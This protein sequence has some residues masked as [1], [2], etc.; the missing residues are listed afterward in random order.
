MS[1]FASPD[2]VLSR[3]AAFEELRTSLAGGA[4]CLE[5]TGLWGS[6]RALVIAGL[7]H[8]AGRP[9]LLVTA[10]P[11]ERHRGA[12]DI[13]FFLS[14]LALGTAAREGAAGRRVLELPAPES[15]S[16]R[17]GRNREQ[18][19]ERA[20][21]CYA[22]IEGGGLVIVAT[23]SALSAALLTP[24][25]FVGRTGRL[26]VGQSISRDEL[27]FLL[28]RAGYERVE[29]VVEVGQWSLRGGIVD[30]FSPARERPVRAEFLGDEIESLRLFDPTT[31][32]SVDAVAEIE[33]LPLLTKDA[34]T[35]TVTAYLP[36]NTL[37][38]L[39]D[40]ALLEAP[41]DDAPAAVPLHRLLEGY[42]RL[43]MPLLSR[44]SGG[45]ARI[46]MG[47]RSVGA[48]RGQFKALAEEIKGWR[49]EGFAVRLAVDDDRQAERVR[50]TLVEHELEPWPGATLW[51]PEGLGVI[52]GECGSGFQL[53]ALGLVLLSER[54]VFG[55]QR[56]R[57]RRP[58]F[59]RGAAIAAFTDL[60]PNDLVVHEDH[61]IGRYHGLR[62]LRTDERDA[63]FLLLE[64]A[65]GGRLY[66]PVARLDLITKYMGAP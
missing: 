36:A 40:P 29:T 17:G 49:E 6:S 31:Q 59:Q 32:R 47:T 14:S 65:E 21:C 5:A 38:T 7:A 43:E 44:R 33:V 28:G 3:W 48:V 42:Q 20:L 53:P 23:P 11:V 66:L 45:P 37:V 46:D 35:A 25:E 41:P 54:E 8:G 24:E 61:G 51:S 52:V 19:A 56:R 62:T 27:L 64:Y 30:V 39:E 55:A 18:A 4:P 22:L 16:N 26:A 1:A 10:G 34:E 50:Q 58:L 15:G 13:G 57:L 2:S 12:V 60:A 63:D 9:I